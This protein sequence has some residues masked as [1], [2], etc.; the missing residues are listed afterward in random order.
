MGERATENKRFENMAFV[1]DHYARMDSPPCYCTWTNK[2]CVLM[3]AEYYA[4]EGYYME[5]DFGPK[6]K[7]VVKAVEREVERGNF[8][9]EFDEAMAGLAEKGGNTPPLL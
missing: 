4:V 6:A 9:A 5:G 1:E 3:D 7:R 8:T 2:W